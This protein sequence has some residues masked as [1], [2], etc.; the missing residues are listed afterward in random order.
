MSA[1]TLVLDGVTYDV[2]PRA[3]PTPTPDPTPTP[4]PVPGGR[5]QRRVLWHHGWSGPAIGSWPADVRARLTT[6][7]LAMSQSAR[8]GTGQL[9]PP[10][11][12]T[13]QEVASLVA[14]GVDVLVGIGGSGD[15]GIT[16]T[17]AGQVAEAV[18][19]VL[20][21]QTSLGTTGVCLDLEGAPGQGWTPEAM[22][23]LGTQLAA[24]GQHVA[25]WSALYGGRLAGWGAVA[26]AL[27]DRLSHWQRGFYDFV[28]AQDNRLTKI[29]TDD[30]TAM[31]GYVLRDDQ[32][33]C[34]FAPVGATSRTPVPVMRAAFTAA[35][36]ARPTVGWSVWE[37]RQ[38]SA[39]G[40]PATL[41]LARL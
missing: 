24:H 17:T 41:A 16:I 1:G 32:L 6:V 28:E 5:G 4:T 38:D 21:W 33:V 2:T 40:W 3:T 25:I 36:A 29:V 31:R 37:D 9:R 27:G 23:S 12:V 26:Q 11:G 20:G 13:R 18:T 7:C 19:S 22:V 34:S 30:L 8:A 10:P 14:D 39:A 15:G 35:L